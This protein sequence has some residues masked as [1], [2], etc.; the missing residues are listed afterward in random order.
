MDL[1]LDG[2]LTLVSGST[3]GIGFAIAKALANEG[4][5]VIVNGRTDS[6]VEDAIKKLQSSGVGGRL[7][8]FAGDLGTSEGVS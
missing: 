6:R 8:G 4:A 7:E 5:H 3:G 2:K 1:Q